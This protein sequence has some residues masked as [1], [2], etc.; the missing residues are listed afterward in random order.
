MKAI[1]LILALI[2]SSLPLAGQAR[3]DVVRVEQA[4]VRGTVPGQSATG[5]FMVLEARRDARLLGASSP[6]AKAVEIH[7]MKLS[8]QVMTMRA[9]AGIDLPAGRA[10]ALEPGGYHLMLLG[11]RR[12][13]Q[14]GDTVPLRLVFKAPTGKSF[15]QQVKA[16]T[17]PLGEA[18]RTQHERHHHAH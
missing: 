18:G 14:A 1:S 8:G 13:L 3:S 9:I 5:A 7:E 15:N 2:A 16:V 10:V 4:W 17:R 6:V 12:P 11:L